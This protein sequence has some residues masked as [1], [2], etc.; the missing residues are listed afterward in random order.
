MK[1]RPKVGDCVEFR[2]RGVHRGEIVAVAVTGVHFSI[3]TVV[4]GKYRYR[5]IGL[6]AII[7]ILPGPEGGR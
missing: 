4:E 6:D 7:R 3:K 5:R 1:E 2:H